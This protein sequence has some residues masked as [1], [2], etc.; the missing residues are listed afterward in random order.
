MRGLFAAAIV[1][2]LA[3]SVAPARADYRADLEVAWRVNTKAQPPTG[4]GP[5][6]FDMS[7]ARVKALCKGEWDPPKPTGGLLREWTAHCSELPLNLGFK[8]Y[9]A[10]LYFYENRLVSVTITKSVGRTEGT[11]PFARV[12]SALSEKYG[13]VPDRTEDYRRSDDRRLQELASGWDSLYQ[14]RFRRTG[15]GGEA[16]KIE[17]VVFT[18]EGASSMVLTYDSQR[19]Q[20]RQDALSHELAEQTPTAH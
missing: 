2:S 20:D 6:E 9:E 17:L 16:A 18:H 19:R 11:A 3:C 1:G 4:L 14:W 13:M 15:V 8:G 5:L 7:A 12:R 10:S